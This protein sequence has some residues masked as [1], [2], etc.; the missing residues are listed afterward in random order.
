MPSTSSGSN[1]QAKPPW[2]TSQTFFSMSMLKP[3]A[4]LQGLVLQF[5]ISVRDARS[6]WLKPQGLLLAA[7][8]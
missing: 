5:L 2:L 1:F 8:R 4:V 6:I 7:H 3:I